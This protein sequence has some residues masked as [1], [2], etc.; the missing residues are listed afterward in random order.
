M[1][2]YEDILPA[3]ARRLASGP[4]LLINITND[5]WFGRTAEPYEH[6]ALAVFRSVEHRLDMVRAVNTGVSA[7][8]DATGRVR[9]KTRVGRSGRAADAPPVTLL[10]EVA[11]LPGGGLYRYVGELFGFGCLAGLALVL[12]RS[13]GY[14]ADQRCSGNKTGPAVG[15]IER[16]ITQRSDLVR[17]VLGAR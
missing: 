11:M 16:R 17:L 5:A 7:H 15:S 2:C 10:V 9:D 12:V 13:A 3:F 1:I 14:R 6:L 8:I 4:N